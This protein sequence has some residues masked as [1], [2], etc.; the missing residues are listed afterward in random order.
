VA[1]IEVMIAT[2]AVRN[3]I[4]EGKTFQLPS[5]IETGGQ[6]GMQSMDKV[7]ADL[8]RNGHVNKEDALSRAIDPENFQRFLQGG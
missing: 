6:F 2:S 1:S 8:C 7:L 5:V 3:L 4:R